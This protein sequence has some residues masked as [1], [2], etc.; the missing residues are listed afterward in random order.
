[1][2]KRLPLNTIKQI[3][4]ESL[5][6]LICK[7][8]LA[9]M[10]DKKPLLTPQESETLVEEAQNRGLYRTIKLHY[11]LTTLVRLLKVDLDSQ[12][13]KNKWVVAKMEAT[14]GEYKKIANLFNGKF[15]KPQNDS[16]AKYRDLVIKLLSSQYIENRDLLLNSWEFTAVKMKQ[17]LLEIREVGRLISYPVLSEDTKKLITETRY[18]FHTLS[19]KLLDTI[20]GLIHDYKT[21]PEFKEWLNKSGGSIETLKKAK[22]LIS[23]YSNLPPEEK[24]NLD[25]AIKETSDKKA[26]DEDPV[27]LFFQNYPYEE[28]GLSK[29]Q[30]AEVTKFI[31]HVKKRYEIAK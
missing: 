3:S 17:Y 18:F 11:D 16:Q 1:M 10:D 22:K 14:L 25:R 24:L 4:D 7:N 29:K 12:T 27:Y 19:G 21:S 2:S 30:K 15:L 5:L 23:R 13:F 31:K 8:T 6:S 28:I 9:G 26:A 20:N